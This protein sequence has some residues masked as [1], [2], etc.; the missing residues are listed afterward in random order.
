[1]TRVI[2][3]TQFRA[4]RRGHP[5]TTRSIT[6]KD[7]PMP[8]EHLF[9]VDASSH[10]L[11]PQK[12]VVANLAAV[13]ARLDLATGRLD[14]VR[15]LH[16]DEIRHDC[17]VTEHDEPADTLD[18]L[19]AAARA[20]NATLLVA[21]GAESM[22]RCLPTLAVTLTPQDQRWVCTRRLAQ[23]LWPEAPGYELNT[24][25]HHLAL[26]EPLAGGLHLGYYGFP[27][28]CIAVL[29]GLACRDMTETGLAVTPALLRDWTEIIPLRQAARFQRHAGYRP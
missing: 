16:D 8:Y 22:A 2:P 12:E 17:R 9:V 29:L 23:H 18:A 15:Q 10:G 27:A 26:D 7:L 21:H 28:A 3:P 6:T 11:D 20:T 4:L 5:S 14:A 19:I 13:G 1:M 25:R 24:L